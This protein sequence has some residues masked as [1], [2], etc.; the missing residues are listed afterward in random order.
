MS[1]YV[2][3]VLYHETGRRHDRAELERTYRYLVATTARLLNVSAVSNELGAKRETIQARLATL[4][5]SF[6]LNVLPGHRS[7]EHRSL[8]AHPKIHA[9][10]TSIAS[11]AAR[12]GVESAPNV[13][14]SMVE[15]FV[16]NE[17]FAQTQWAGQRITVRHWRDNARKLE[18]DAVLTGDDGR[19]VAIE[20]KAGA[21]VRPDH[22][23][24]LHAFLADEPDAVRGVV[25]YSGEQ[26]LRLD[27]RIW[28][29]PI[30]ALWEPPRAAPKD[31][32]RPSS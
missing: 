22:L 25:F 12:L 15:T 19:S 30:S 28:A 32:A 6:L 2:E 13:W 1:E 17:L 14:G 20:V 7:G 9:V 8:T 10:D 3:G 23:R 4:E 26:I 18:V 5:A 21:D 11:W 29:L 27:D 16:I 24:G 31:R